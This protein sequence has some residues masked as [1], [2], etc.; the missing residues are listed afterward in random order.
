[1]FLPA[2]LFHKFG[3]TYL[4]SLRFQTILYSAL[5]MY[6]TYSTLRVILQADVGVNREIFKESRVIKFYILLILSIPTFTLWSLLGLREPFIYLSLGLVFLGVTLITTS[7]KKIYFGAITLVLGELLLAHT[8]FYLFAI[9]ATALLLAS[10]TD[11]SISLKKKLLI[12]ISIVLI[13]LT[14]GDTAKG[15]LDLRIDFQKNEPVQSD[16]T[17]EITNV[18]FLSVSRIA[19]QKCIVNNEGGPIILS[20]AK[21]LGIENEQPGNEQPGNE[22]P[23]Y[24]PS[25]NYGSDQARNIIDPRRIGP[26]ILNFLLFPVNFEKFSSLALIGV[27][28]S[29]FWLPVYFFCVWE[30]ILK[31]RTKTT[32]S[33]IM[34]L[35]LYF[36]LLFVGFSAATEIN[37]GTAI[38]HRSVVL[39]PLII[40]TLTLYFNRKKKLSV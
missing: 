21:A 6:L 38:R 12:V 40:L 39:F 17:S 3:F 24:S 20:L 35:S 27:I 18:D 30:I 11:K 14:T 9:F 16:R 31:R 19:L 33:P 28:E 36:I 4:I 25:T 2:I 32:F 10:L 15:V 5:A 8:K 7:S 26:G 37:F 13:I 23:G 29:I 22:Q 34:R 1:V